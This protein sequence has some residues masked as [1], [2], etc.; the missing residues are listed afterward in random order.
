MGQ[1]ESSYS[2]S[3]D[4]IKKMDSKLMQSSLQVASKLKHFNM[5]IAK[6]RICEIVDKPSELVLMYR[7]AKAVFT[8][9]LNFELK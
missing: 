3:D 5:K 2:V 6:W 7:H 4:F 1:K 8:S 9:D